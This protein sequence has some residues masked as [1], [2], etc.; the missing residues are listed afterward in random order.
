MNFATV[1]YQAISA[2]YTPTGSN[3]R[4]SIGSSAVVIVATP[5]ST[6][7]RVRIGN[8]VSNIGAGQALSYLIVVDNL[9]TQAAVGRLQVPV[10][11]DFAGASYTCISAALASCGANGSGSIDTEVSLAPGGVVIYRI[12]VTSPLAPERTISQTVTVVT[13]APTTDTD[14]SN[15]S[16]ADIDPMGLLADGYE[17]TA[18]TE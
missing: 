2:S 15:N 12:N 6:D 14:A 7:L 5:S 18:V 11:A 3:H 10:S 1:G 9:G 16:A 17:D 13:K 4:A 8:G